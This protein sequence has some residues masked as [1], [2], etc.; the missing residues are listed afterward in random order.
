MNPRS[1][2]LSVVGIDTPPTVTRLRVFALVIAFIILL[3]G[4]ARWPERSAEIG[5]I[6]EAPS[7]SAMPAVSDFKYFPALYVNQ[8]RETPEHIESF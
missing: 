1:P 3:L 2:H 8:A 5:P 6:R 7:Q 4:A